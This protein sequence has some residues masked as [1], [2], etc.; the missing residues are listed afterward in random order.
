MA[1]QMNSWG[2]APKINDTQIAPNPTKLSLCKK[3][4]RFKSFEEDCIGIGTIRYVVRRDP[5][6]CGI[7]KSVLCQRIG[8][9]SSLDISVATSY[10]HSPPSRAGT[11]DLRAISSGH[12]L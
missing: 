3:R 10:R 6:R 8:R 11:P 9:T 5:R 4:A 2:G 1:G 7:S 12:L